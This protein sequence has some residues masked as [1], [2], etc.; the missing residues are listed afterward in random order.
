MYRVYH[1]L[2]LYVVGT[3]GIF[4]LLH[5]LIHRNLPLIVVGLFFFCFLNGLISLWEIALGQNI[6]YI[7]TLYIEMKEKYKGRYL[8]ACTDFFNY[9][10][11]TKEELL[12]GK[13]W[14]RVWATYSLYDPSYQNPESFGFFIDVGNGWSTILPSIVFT[15]AITYPLPFVTPVGLGIVCLCK[16][17]QEFYGCV[18]YFV[19]YLWNKRYVNVPLNEVLGFVGISN[20]LWISFPLLGVYACIRLILDQNFQIF[21]RV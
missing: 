3:V 21:G 20:G 10:L 12:S 6:D 17:Y 13:Y 7:K 18:I 8:D 9:P 15:L 11:N 19:S 2:L 1:F 14:S 5:Y 16:F 4:S